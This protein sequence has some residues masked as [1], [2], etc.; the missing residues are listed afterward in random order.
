[1]RTI[2]SRCLFAAMLAACGLSLVGCV[3]VPARYHE[4]V[5]VPGH[6]APGHV[7]IGGHWR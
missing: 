2:M 1:M 6:W 4:R 7:W 3:V 5:W